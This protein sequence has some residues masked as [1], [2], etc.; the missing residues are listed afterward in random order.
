MC[1]KLSG[2]RY[3]SFYS[4]SIH[5]FNMVFFSKTR[6]SFNPF[7]QKTAATSRNFWNVDQF[8]PKLWLATRKRY[9]QQT[10]LLFLVIWLASERSRYI[11]EPA[12]NPNFFLL[13]IPIISLPSFSPSS[14][15]AH[16]IQQDTL[17]WREKRGSNRVTWI[18]SQDSRSFFASFLLPS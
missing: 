16:V 11:S 15:H 7:D 12:T 2:Q 17:E 5:C 10:L 13:Y 8:L 6:P 14:P 3:A 9:E 18:L 1:H 4:T